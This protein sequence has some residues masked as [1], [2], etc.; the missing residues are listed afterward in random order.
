MKNFLTILLVL[1][2]FITSKAQDGGQRSLYTKS[3][4]ITHTDFVNEAD[5]I[6]LMIING[7]EKKLYID[8]ETL[9]IENDTLKSIGQPG[10]NTWNFA[11]QTL[12][13]TSVTLDV[14]NGIN[15][16][17]SLSGA[18]TFTLS[19]VE[20]GMEG[21]IEVTNGGSTTYKITF[22]GYTFIISKSVWDT[23][24]RVYVSGGTLRDSF[25]WKYVGGVVQ[26]SGVLDLK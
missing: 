6:L 10:A 16:K 8:S 1:L 13:G 5:T 14:L 17:L 15:A 24:D 26:V 11:T 3:E 4:K 7:V 21:T 9:Y 12:S 19:N 22:S 23:G 18:T 2:G 20:D 25:S